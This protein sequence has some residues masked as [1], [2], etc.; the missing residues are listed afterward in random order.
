VSSVQS[1][2]SE[3][4]AAAAL[5][6]LDAVPAALREGRP[7][8]FPPLPRRET[9]SFRAVASATHAANRVRE[10]RGRRQGTG[11]SAGDAAGD[12]RLP[13]M[14]QSTQTMRPWDAVSNDTLA[15]QVLLR[16]SGF[17]SEI[18]A[19]HIDPSLRDRVRSIDQLSEPTFASDDV[20]V[21]VCVHAPRVMRALEAHPGSLHLRFHSNTPPEWFCGISYGFELSARKGWEEMTR[22]SRRCV[23]AIADSAHN[24]REIRE[25]G[26]TDVTLVP[27][28]LAPAEN[29]PAWTGGGGYAISVGR[30]APNKRI[31][32][33]LR[34]VAAYQHLHDPE[35]GLV[36][37]GSDRGLE[38]YGAACRD[39]E[40]ELG[41]RNVRWVGSVEE[42]EKLRLMAAADAYLCASDH[43]GFCVPIVESFRLG[44][45]VV[46]RATSAVTDTCG[47]ALAVDTS[48]PAFL[49]NVMRVVVSDADLRTRLIATQDLEAKRF[50]PALV[51]EQ[52]LAWARTH[53]TTA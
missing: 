7:L 8:S 45:P 44:L 27:I 3:I 40:R 16:R 18:F 50:D 6:G 36:L 22:L 51:G 29:P 10:A 39:L 53:V 14:H 21:H 5:A 20:L 24:V 19:E 1:P 32:F 49:A 13:A 35:F 37:V 34:T 2:A 52:V 4:V 17:S 48:D 28:L 46:A 42:A 12:A 41:V 43:E 31:D 47:E 9:L 26:M 15:I 11:T 30:I 33:L 38:R 25:V 23:S